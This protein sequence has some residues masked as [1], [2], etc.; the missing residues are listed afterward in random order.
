MAFW[1]TFKAVIALAALLLALVVGAFAET[2]RLG[3]EVTSESAIWYQLLATALWSCLAVSVLLSVWGLTLR[4]W[5]PFA[6]AALLSGIF[7]VFAILSIGF[8]TLIMAI[9][10]LVVAVALGSRS[11]P[12]GQ[13]R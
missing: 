3:P 11:H 2:Q 5:Q 8:L 7:S 4:R 9:I 12:V 6:L 10:Q 1:Q 13:G